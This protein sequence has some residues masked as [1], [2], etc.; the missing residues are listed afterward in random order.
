MDPETKGVNQDA[1]ESFAE[2]NEVEVMQMKWLGR[3]K[4]HEIHASVVAKL[5]TKEHA[6]ELLQEGREVFMFGSVVK[7]TPFQEE[8][9]I[10]AYLRCQQFGHFIK[11]CKNEKQCGKCA[12]RGHVRC[13]TRTIKCLRCGG[14][15]HAM[16]RKCLEVIKEQVRIINTRFHA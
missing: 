16:Y 7:V 12:Q 8:R 13:D 10:K 14:D 11:H 6:E 2:E 3:P 1:I 15:H 5:A 4:E 9:R